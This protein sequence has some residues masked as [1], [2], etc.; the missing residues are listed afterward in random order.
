KIGSVTQI[1]YKCAG[2]N[3]TNA[4]NRHQA[5]TSIV[6]RQLLLD[7]RITGLYFGIKAMNILQQMLHDPFELQR[8]VAT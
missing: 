8:Q 6:L 3:R 1:R 5:C 7:L 4:R 2:G